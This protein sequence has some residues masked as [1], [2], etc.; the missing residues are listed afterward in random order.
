MRMVLEYKVRKFICSVVLA[1]MRDEGM[2]KN[3]EAFLQFFYLI[4][5]LFFVLV[6][7]DVVVIAIFAAPSKYFREP[8]FFLD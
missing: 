2:L 6:D 3:L 7:R 5:K 1:K 4:F 8:T